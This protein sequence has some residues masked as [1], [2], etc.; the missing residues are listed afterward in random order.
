[1]THQENQNLRDMGLTPVQIARTKKAL[2]GF[3]INSTSGT[4]VTQSIPL[5]GTA[6]YLLGIKT[7]N[8]TANSAAPLTQLNSFDLILNNEKIIDN[9][10]CGFTETFFG[11]N[12]DNE[13]YVE[14]FRVL[15]GKDVLNINLTA[16]AGGADQV[17]FIVFYAL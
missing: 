16:A 15:T 1:M 8:K 12:G 17:N 9:I 13:G 4:T 14:V 7:F 11:G 6:K 3:S 10:N 2:K 5:P